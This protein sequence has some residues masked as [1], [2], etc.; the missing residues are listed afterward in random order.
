VRLRPG[1]ERVVERAGTRDRSFEH[2]R[3]ELAEAVRDERPQEDLRPPQRE[4][5]RR[6]DREP[7]R[8]VRPRV[9]EALE[10]RIEEA[11]AMRDL[12]ALELPVPAY[13]LDGN[14]GLGP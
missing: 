5:G 10:D 13:G 4:R 14:Q 8:A 2:V 12:P 3:G 11:G 1:H 9:A 7:D 6:G